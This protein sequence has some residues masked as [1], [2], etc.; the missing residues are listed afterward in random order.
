MMCGP[1]SAFRLQVMLWHLCGRR[2]SRGSWGESATGIVELDETEPSCVAGLPQREGGEVASRFKFPFSLLLQKY[3]GLFKVPM[4]SLSSWL[5][6]QLAFSKIT[7][8]SPRPLQSLDSPGRH[9]VVVSCEV[10]V[11]FSSCPCCW[12]LQLGVKL[13]GKSESDQLSFRFWNEKINQI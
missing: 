3:E 9:L 7:F 6:V 1:P 12:R 5:E 10:T 11:W 2:P 13:L 4:L 8:T